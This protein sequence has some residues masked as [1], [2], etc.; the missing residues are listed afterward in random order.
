VFGDQFLLNMTL[1]VCPSIEEHDP[2]P[3]I[4]R[5]NTSTFVKEIVTFHLEIT[6]NA[7]G[8]PRRNK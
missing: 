1:S 6:L 8:V 7:N 5:R 4:L 2:F 3:A